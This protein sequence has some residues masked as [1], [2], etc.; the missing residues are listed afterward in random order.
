MPLINVENAQ[1]KTTSVEIKTLTLSGKQVTLSVFRQVQEE[2]LLDDEQMKLNGVPW[3]LINYFWKEES[4]EHKIHVLWQKGSELRRD[5]ILKQPCVEI[6]YRYI[7]R[8]HYSSL[9][10]K[11][12]KNIREIGIRSDEDMSDRYDEFNI[13]AINKKIEKMEND[14]EN[15]KHGRAYVGQ[16]DESRL[17]WITNHAGGDYENEKIGLEKKKRD[18]NFITKEQL[19]KIACEE[20]YSEICQL[21]EN[22]RNQRDILENER[23]LFLENEKIMQNYMQEY[24]SII[25]SLL[26]LPQLF[27]AV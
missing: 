24:R 19:I 17:E 25:D 13:H 18:G 10:E 9:R 15:T 21:K 23:Q 1:I 20:M 8:R 26:D 6:N 22:L 5:I 14:I 12:N 2:S 3:G 7:K 11:L 16:S 4:P 27:I